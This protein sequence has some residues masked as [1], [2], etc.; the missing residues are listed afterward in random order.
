MWPK[1][2]E[3]FYK[4]VKPLGKGGFGDVWLGKAVDGAPEKTPGGLD[5]LV[6]IKKVDTSNKAGEAY[7]AREIIILQELNHPNIVKL[8]KVFD[9]EKSNQSLGYS[10]I[11]L[12]FAKGPTLEKV[13]NEGG[14]VGIPMARV[15]S[16]QLV[17]TIAYLHSHAVIH[18]D[19]KPDNIIITGATLKDDDLWDDGE[20][21]EAAAKK[22]KWHIILIDFGFVR[23]LSAEDTNKDIALHN[24]IE[25]KDIEHM[26]EVGKQS[27]TLNNELINNAMSLDGSNSSRGRKKER[28]LDVSISHARVRDLSAIGNRNY[29]AP[30]I[31]NGVHKKKDRSV[32]GRKRRQ[33]IA[34]F[35]S[36]YGMDADAFSLGMVLRY[37][38][39]GVSPGHDVREFIAMKNNFFLKI[40]SKIK[41]K[42]KKKGKDDKVKR[43]KKYRLSQACPK[44]ATKLVVGLTLWDPK[45]RT[46]VRAARFY[47]WLHESED[48]IDSKECEEMKK[49]QV[50]FL[51][52]DV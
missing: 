40:M 29:A 36:N 6:A 33:S 43:K 9:V 14:A 31:I 46:T 23:A 26:N 11:A 39:T 37:A 3:D 5:E 35:V 13:L 1:Q 18:R 38:L 10:F 12:S 44:E 45:K 34:D 28:T 30:E 48:F 24:T 16:R 8:L 7:A 32:R 50:T 27:S 52:V 42:I 49:A 22:N 20:I 51:D 17:F 21:G 47:P 4:P 2:V 19:I 25:Q 15:L 41:K